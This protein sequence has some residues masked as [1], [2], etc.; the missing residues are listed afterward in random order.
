[1]TKYLLIPKENARSRG[2]LDSYTPPL[3]AKT[4]Y[5]IN[6]YRGLIGRDP[7]LKDLH[8]LV[9]TFSERY[10][11]GE[12]ASINIIGVDEIESYSSR[13][14]SE[15]PVK[16]DFLEFPG[17]PV[18]ELPDDAAEDL[19]GKVSPNFYALD[20]SLTFSLFQ[21]FVRKKVKS[22]LAEEDFW[23]LQRVN[24]RSAR[25]QGFLGTGRGVRVAV[26][27]T[28][29]NA[30]HGELSGRV[31]K[32][33]SRIG[34]PQAKGQDYS[35]HGTMVSSLICGK[36]LGV[37]PDAEI[38]DLAMMTRDNASAQMEDFMMGVI[39]AAKTEQVKILNISGGLSYDD[40]QFSGLLTHF[41]ELIYVVAAGNDGPDKVLCPGSINNVVTVGA[42]ERNDKV[43]KKSGGK[44]MNMDHIAEPYY[45]P[46]LV[47]PGVDVTVAERGGRYKVASGTSF[48]APIVTGVLAAL[49]ETFEEKYDRYSN[50]DVIETLFEHCQDLGEHPERQGKGLLVL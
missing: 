15:K 19:V 49:V 26:L 37:A 48:A 27:D 41:P 40:Q 47:A 31:A 8:T 21:P 18:I 13:T 20:L 16:L 12:S 1:L 23:H 11:G 33:Y 2:V 50:T 28:G 7:V 46:D 14:W 42:I 6:Q 5:L 22:E 45:V 32:S 29:V 44:Y 43:W 4:D 17:F 35:G 24:L 36:S 38:V 10:W 3:R 25:E 9:G 30:E 39:I 34:R